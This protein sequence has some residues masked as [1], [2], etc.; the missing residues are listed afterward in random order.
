MRIARPH[1]NPNRKDPYDAFRFRVEIESLRVG[2]FSDA[3]GIAFEAD[4]ETF[5]EGG[6]NADERH[7]LSAVKSSGRVVLKRGLGDVQS[8]W[9]WFGEV[10]TGRIR[11]RNLTIWL[12]SPDDARKDLRGWLFLKACPVKWAGPDFHAKTSEVA[13]ESVEF[14]HQGQSDLVGSRT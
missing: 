7:L 8:L 3:S 12:V 5:R 11:R 2:G 10:A 6:Y 9:R 14:I 13:I 1:A 4:V